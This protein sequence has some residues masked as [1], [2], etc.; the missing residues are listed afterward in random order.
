MLA[1]ILDSGIL[2]SSDSGLLGSLG[3]IVVG[4]LD[5]IGLVSGVEVL[6]NLEVDVGILTGIGCRDGLEEVTVNVEGITI[7]GSVTSTVLGGKLGN[8]P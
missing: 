7:V 6:L 5:F 2:G 3:G 8:H 1:H 4:I